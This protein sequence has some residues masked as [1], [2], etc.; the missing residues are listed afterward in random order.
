MAGE[1][2][3]VVPTPTLVYVS[4]AE[5]RRIYGVSDATLKRWRRNGAPFRQR[6]GPV[7]AAVSA[8]GILDRWMRGGRRAS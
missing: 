2:G 5:L 3:P 6:R 1:A 4:G 7:L 8:R